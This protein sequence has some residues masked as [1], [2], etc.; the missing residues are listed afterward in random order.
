MKPLETPYIPYSQGMD[1]VIGK[2]FTAKANGDTLVCDLSYADVV[3]SLSNGV[4][5]T[6][7]VSSDGEYPPYYTTILVAYYNTDEQKY[8]A[9]GVDMTFYADTQ[10]ENMSYGEII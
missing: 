2:P 10:T 6:L 7:Y 8:I 4:V 3:K 9:G 1:A 5:P